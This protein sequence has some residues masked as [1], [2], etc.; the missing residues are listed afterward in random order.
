MTMPFGQE[1]SGDTCK[2]TPKP[3]DIEEGAFVLHEWIDNQW[4]KEL[5]LAVALGL[6]TPESTQTASG[7]MIAAITIKG[8]WTILPVWWTRSYME[9]A[10]ENAIGK[11][12]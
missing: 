9:R 7:E 12:R 2:I 10:V 4:E 6:P 3:F 5:N 8:L 11:K 1:N